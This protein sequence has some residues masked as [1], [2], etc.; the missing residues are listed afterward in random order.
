MRICSACFYC[1][2]RVYLVGCTRRCRPAWRCTGASWFGHLGRG[3]H[4]HCRTEWSGRPRL[5]R[6]PAPLTRSPS[7]ARRG[8]PRRSGPARRLAPWRVNGH[9]THRLTRR[10][11]SVQLQWPLTAR[12]LSS[13]LDTLG[14]TL[15]N[16]SKKY[17][18]CNYETACMQVRGYK[19]HFTGRVCVCRDTSRLGIKC[20]ITQ[21]GLNKPH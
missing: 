11:L 1:C 6:P 18:T 12:K 7:A 16:I 13:Q 21:K 5:P 9:V 14:H 4:T 20:A 15:L 3:T 2:F 19:T 8:S 17:P 10:G